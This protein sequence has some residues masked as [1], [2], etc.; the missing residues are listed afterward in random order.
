MLRPPLCFPFF[1]L[2]IARIIAIFVCVGPE[3]ANMRVLQDSERPALISAGWRPDTQG[4]LRFVVSHAGFFAFVFV[5][6]LVGF[7]FFF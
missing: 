5:C 1:F 2:L 6:C 4:E 3:L 7:F